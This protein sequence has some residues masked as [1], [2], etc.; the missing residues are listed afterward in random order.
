MGRVCGRATLAVAVVVVPMLGGCAQGGGGTEGFTQASRVGPDDGSDACHAQAVALDETGDFF[1]QDI[2]QGAAMGAVGGAILGG[3]AGGNL[4]SALIG[5]AAGGAVGAAGGYWEA[6]QQQSQN[7][8]Q[9]ESTV[10]GNLTAENDQINKTQIAFNDDMDCR[11]EQ[12]AQIKAAYKAGTITEDQAAAELSAQKTLAQRD[13]ALAKTIN[14]QIQSRGAQ[15]DTAADNLDGASAPPAATVAALSK[16]GVIR[17]A[18]P[19]LLRPDRQAPVVG[20][21]NR[22]ED[23][24]V[25]GV[26]GD[27]ALVQAADGSSGYAPLTDVREAGTYRAIVV[28][29]EEQ[30][31]PPEPEATASSDDNAAYVPPAAASAPAA[32]PAAPPP[33]TT[34]V[35]QLDGSNAA[36][37]DAFAQNVAVSQSAVSNGFQLAT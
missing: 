10:E 7:T 22:H 8:A 21:V 16:P 11:F 17:R 37:R 4:K 2:L 1:G 36:S 18:A 27:Y 5:A 19:L 33:S 25:T 32:A 20:S 24:T 26:S 29:P 9:L 12:A 13:L 14:G 28:P 15:F 23:V 30:I 34:A 3:L 6:L 31:P 35:Q